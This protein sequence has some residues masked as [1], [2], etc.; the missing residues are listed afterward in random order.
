MKCSLMLTAIKN[1]KKPK[2]PA[3]VNFI[4][5][6]LLGNFPL[7][8]GIID[9]PRQ[10]WSPNFSRVMQWSHEDNVVNRHPNYYPNKK[11]KLR[12]HPALH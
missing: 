7:T 4:L 1:L 12:F 3:F 9:H 10:V 11:P 8:P 2:K 5:K 6:E